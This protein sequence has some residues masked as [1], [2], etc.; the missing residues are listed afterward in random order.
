MVCRVAKHQMAGHGRL[1]SQ[2]NGLEIPHLTNHDDIRIL[3]QS[4]A[5][6]RGKALGVGADLPVVDDTFL[7]LMDKLDGI[8]DGQDVVLAVF[9][10]F[11]DNRRQGRRFTRTGRPGHQHQ[12]FGQMGQTGDNRRQAELFDGH[13]LAGNFPK[14]RA[15]PIFLLE[16]I[17]AVAGQPG[18]FIAE[19]NISRSPQRP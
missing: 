6:G 2:G 1:H 15:D 19:I 4:P 10:A 18:N 12:S 13:N 9:V 16:K 3:T 11:I 17:A 5:Q 7:T 14:N 8:F